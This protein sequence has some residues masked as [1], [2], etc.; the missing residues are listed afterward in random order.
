MR[1]SVLL[2][3]FDPPALARGSWSAMR[4]GGEIIGAALRTQTGVKPLYVSIGHRISLPGAIRIVLGQADRYRLPEP[5]R[6]ADR[7]SKAPLEKA[8]S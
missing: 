4:D 5:Q 7:L 1:Q 6:R 2:G 8:S 3:T